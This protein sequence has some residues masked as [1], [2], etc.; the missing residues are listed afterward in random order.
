M[1]LQ[2][3]FG[4]RGLYYLKVCLQNKVIELS[5]HFVSDSHTFPMRPKAAES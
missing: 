1:Q 4:L 3:V 2:L 5:N